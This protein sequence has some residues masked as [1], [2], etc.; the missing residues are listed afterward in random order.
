MVPPDRVVE[1]GDALDIL[2]LPDQQLSWC[3][4]YLTDHYHFA[5]FGVPGIEF[6]TGL[7]ADYHQ[8]SDEANAIRYDVL[9][10]ILE[11]RNRLIEK[12]VHCTE[13]PEFDRPAWLITPPW[14]TTA[15]RARQG[16]VASC[17]AGF[18]TDSCGLNRRLVTVYAYLKIGGRIMRKLRIFA[19]ISAIVS[20]GGLAVVPI[21]AAEEGPAGEAVY[22]VTFEEAPLST[23]DGELPGLQATNP[24]VRGERRL[25]PLS[26]ASRAYLRFLEQRHEAYVATMSQRIARTPQVIFVYRAASNGVALRVTPDE[27]AKLR[28]I[29]GVVRVEPDRAFTLGTDRGPWFIGADA[30][31]DGSVLVGAGNQG[32]GITIGIIDTGI[33]QEHPSFSDAPH[34]GHSFTN[35]LGSGAASSDNKSSTGSHYSSPKSCDSSTTMHS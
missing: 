3:L 25:D 12:Y 32:E 27:A 31:W 6:V 15:G 26:D 24:Q 18:T 2:V 9:Q 17:N 29:P 4:L 16:T 11:V 28:S 10:R 7:H 5:R 13:P 30:V 20:L 21:R 8:P 34:D 23:Y 19:S 14:A 22:I 35:P 1:L 33:N